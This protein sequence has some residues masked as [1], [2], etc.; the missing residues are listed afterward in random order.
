MNRVVW[1]LA[2]ILIAAACNESSEVASPEL[3]AVAFD[4]IESSE[5]GID[6]TNNVENQENFNILTYRNYYNGAGVAIGDINNDGLNDIYFTA[7]MGPNKLYLNKGDLTFE[8]ITEQAGVQGTKYWSTGVSMAD[9]NADG[10]LDIYVCNSGDI[11]GENK[12]NELFINNG[13]LTFSERAAEYGL[14]NLGYS[15]HATFFDYDLDGDLDCFVL[16]NSYKDPE[17]IA[18]YARLRDRP[19]ELGGDKL[20][21]NDGNNRF[22]DVTIDAGIFT[23]QIGFGLGVSVGDLNADGWPD[24]Y[25]SNDFWERDYLYI[26]QQDGTFKEDLPDRMGYTSVSSMGSDIADID[27]DGDLDVF[28]TDMLPPDN[29]RLKAAT[30]FTEYHLE[31]YKFRSNYHYQLLQNCLQVNDGDAKFQET[32]FISGVAATD[33]SWGA[34]IFDFDNDGLKDIFVSN[35]LYHDITDR[36]FI[37]FIGDQ[38]SVRKIVEAKGRYDFRDFLPFLP[39]NQRSNYAFVNNGDLSFTNSAEQLNLAQKS[40]S[41]GAAYGDLDNDG[42]YDLVVNNVNM[43]AFVYRNNSTENSDNHFIKVTLEG[44]SQNKAGIGAH[45]SC[46]HS[47]RRF[48]FILYACTGF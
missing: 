12:E 46:T 38:D 29:Y 36:D 21:R 33:W 5:S 19:D 37:D 35:G 39:N 22:T 42:D 18:L 34:L 4:L 1:T 24:I 20:Y 3:S 8:D 28:S 13:D 43:E 11:E 26:N 31:D 32:A 44:S 45:V 15:T 2:V 40:Y 27:N 16:N 23:S 41:N 7:N 14:N 25:I 10:L 9:V 47:R 30:R 6:F 48:Q 17:R